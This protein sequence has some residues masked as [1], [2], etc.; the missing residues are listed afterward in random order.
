MSKLIVATSRDAAVDLPHAGD[1]KKLFEEHLPCD[2]TRL[3]RVYLQLALRYHPDKWPVEIRKE[4]TELFQAISNVYEN[5]TRPMGR[6]VKRVKCPVAAAAELGDLAELERLLKFQ[7]SKADEEDDVGATPL[8]FAARGGCV[9]AARLLV[10]HGANV[11][12]RNVIGWS[13]LTWAGLGDQESMVRWLVGQGVKVTEEELELVGFAGCAN[14]LAALLE[15][16]EGSVA[17]HRTDTN[18][19]SLLHLVCYGIL[20]LPRDMPE[21]YLAC[22]DLL[23]AVNVPIDAKDKRGRTCLQLLVGHENWMLHQ[24]QE[25]PT[26]LKMVELLCI[27]GANPVARGPQG[28]SALSL[29]E[30]LGLYQVKDVL[31]RFSEG[32]HHVWSRL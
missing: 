32:E 1:A 4:A 31:C 2:D 10:Q 6:L 30:S 26:H 20:N 11:H 21:R 23:L 18:G 8:M 29:A 9:E 16:F 28:N 14:A 12:A 7:A 3:R 22:V 13:T 24:L 15:L 5:L 17:S 19:S 25:S 27:A